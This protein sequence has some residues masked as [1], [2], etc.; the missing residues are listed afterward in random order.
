[1]K[2]HD[3]GLERPAYNI[4][5]SIDAFMFQLINLASRGYYFCYYQQVK[6]RKEPED[7][8]RTLIDLWQ[9]D[10]PYW[11][12]EKRNRGGAPSI[13]YLRF[14]R[15]CLLMSTKGWRFEDSQATPHPFFVRYGM[16]LFDIRKR[17]FYFCGYSVRFARSKETGK[18]SAFVKL[19]QSTYAR[20]HVTMCQKAISERYREREAFEAEFENV[21]WQPYSGVHQQMTRIL[22]EAN[23]RRMRYKGFAPARKKCVR[24]RMRTVNLYG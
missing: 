13:W 16:H 3:K 12:R 8:D 18:H 14:E 10:Q 20:L 17:A 19:D 9:L 6:G 24:W 21:P 23:R 7:Y 2:K 15:Q 1:M 11:K 5:E 22:D 4:V